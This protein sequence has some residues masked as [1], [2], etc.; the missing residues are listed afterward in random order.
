MTKEEELALF[1]EVL[2]RFGDHSYIGPWLK[3][4]AENI[5]WGILNDVPISAAID[6]HGPTEL[7]V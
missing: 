1:E 7:D 6:V 2:Q 4:H 5:K 3:V